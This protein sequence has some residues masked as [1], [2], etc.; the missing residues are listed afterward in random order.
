MTEGNLVLLAE[1]TGKLHQCNPT[2][3]AIWQALSDHPTDSDAAAAAVGERFG[4]SVDRVRRDLVA[5]VE[6]LQ[7]A[8]LV[9]VDR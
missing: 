4:V 7:R 9:E 6:Q 5:F 1:A 8:G 2:G 3:A